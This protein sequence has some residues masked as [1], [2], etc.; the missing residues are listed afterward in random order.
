MKE[1]GFLNQSLANKSVVDRVVDQIT[2]AIIN[3]ELK[4]GD[5]IPTETELCEAFGVG[6]N[7]VREAVKILEAYGVVYIKR[8]EGT[9]VRED[10]NDKM[11][12]PILYGIILQKDSKEQI[13]E[14]RK[15]ID[16][17]MMQVAVGRMQQKDFDRMEKAVACMEAQVRSLTPSSKRIF[18]AD[19]EFHSAIV[20][21]TNNVLLQSIGDYV[22]KI[23]RQSRVMTIETIL[24][25]G[26]TD[27]FLALH[28]TILDTLRT[29][30]IGSVVRVVEEH[31]KYWGSPNPE[32]DHK[33]GA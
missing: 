32:S 20:D 14:L 1:S 23:T 3:G 4:P 7:S 31:Y 25:R 10:Y 24:E 30:N 6:R 17:G 27:D 33:N 9:F 26:A 16:I 8:A 2:D 22:D 21:V 15:V 5:K 13:M 18:E 29:K 19:V 28:Y 11:L 12:Y